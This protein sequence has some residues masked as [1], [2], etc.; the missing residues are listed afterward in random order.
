MGNQSDKAG[1]FMGLHSVLLFFLLTAVPGAAQTKP[2]CEAYFQVIQMDHRIPG[3]IKVGMN[4]EQKNWWDKK[5]QKEYPEL[6]WNGSIDSSE[7]PRFLVIWS[8]EAPGGPVR[9]PKS[10]EQ[11]TGVDLYGQSASALKDV[12]GTSGHPLLRRTISIVNVS[13]PGEPPIEL[14]KDWWFFR[15]Y[16]QRVLAQALAFLTAAPP[17]PPSAS[18]PTAQNP[19]GAS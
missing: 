18:S 16:S 5:G 4:L 11:S 7:K 12:A 6:C 14:T 15:S 10:T 19:H 3:G 8:S 13:A 2:T 17:Y 9:V 1:R